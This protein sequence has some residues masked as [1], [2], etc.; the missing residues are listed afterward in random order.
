MR[1]FF[2]GQCQG[3]GPTMITSCLSFVRQRL[4]HS[5]IKHF[6]L[7]LGERKFRATQLGRR[8]HGWDSPEANWKLPFRISFHF[9][10]VSLAA[11]QR[12]C[13]NTHNS[14]WAMGVDT[15]HNFSNQRGRLNKWQRQF[16][17]SHPQTWTYLSKLNQRSDL[18]RLSDLPAAGLFFFHE[19]F[20]FPH[21]S[22]VS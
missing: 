20:V 5:N 13:S 3:Y 12:I 18:V 9:N 4:P 10:W 15:L 22:V 19:A 16:P 17:L 11:S 14:A 2:W 6:L 8:D 1:D 21:S 7:G